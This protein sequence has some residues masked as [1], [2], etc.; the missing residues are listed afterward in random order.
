MPRDRFLIAP[1]DQTSGVQTNYKPWLIP[2]QAFAQLDNA[3]VFRGRVRKRFGSRWLSDSQLLSRFRIQIDVIAA[4]SANGNVRVN[5]S[6]PL[7]TPAVGQAFSVGNTIFTVFNSALGPQQMYRTD[8]SVAVATY[9]LNNSDY[10][11]TATGA[12]DGTPVY[13]YP[14][15]PVMGLLS[16]DGPTVN[17]EPIV[18]FD[19]RYAYQYTNGRQRS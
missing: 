15:L 5:I 7:L 19:R 12:A 9:D 14:A 4:G 11:I 16:V 13:F 18:G 8:L 10:N 6:D 3:Y 1:F 2:D 17:N